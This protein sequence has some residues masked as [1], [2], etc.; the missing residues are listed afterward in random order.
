[1]RIGKLYASIYKLKH[2]TMRNEIVDKYLETVQFDFLPR[3]VQ[4]VLLAAANAWA[5]TN[6][7]MLDSERASLEKEL[8]E[9]AAR[10]AEIQSTLSRRSLP[11]E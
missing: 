6:E 10:L 5:A 8:A 2:K 4:R 1:M 11:I 7:S 9:K 3:N